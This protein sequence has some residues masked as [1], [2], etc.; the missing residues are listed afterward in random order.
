[1]HDHSRPRFY[2]TYEPAIRPCGSRRCRYIGQCKTHS[3]QV[4]TSAINMIRLDDW[5]AGEPVFRMSWW[6]FAALEQAA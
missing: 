4:M 2:G 1:M 6:R 3:Q 5:W